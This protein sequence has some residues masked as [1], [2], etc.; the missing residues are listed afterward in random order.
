MDISFFQKKMNMNF[1]YQ[2]TTLIPADQKT[3]CFVRPSPGG[4]V[5]ALPRQPYLN[6]LG[7]YFG[8]SFAPPE[9]LDWI[10]VYSAALVM[11]KLMRNN[12]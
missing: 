9:R 8:G 11:W 3:I 7:Q 5:S 6:I 2:S 1:L 10:W 4:G 12:D